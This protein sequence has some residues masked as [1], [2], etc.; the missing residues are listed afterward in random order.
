MNNLKMLSTSTT[1]LNAFKQVMFH[2]RR[3]S[4]SRVGSISLF[5]DLD[6][7]MDERRH[8][9]YRK[10]QHRSSNRESLVLDHSGSNSDSGS[11]VSVSDLQGLDGTAASQIVIVH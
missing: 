8:S 11:V 3:M 2:R 4:L 10:S 9:S 7:L 5:E 6:E 1:L